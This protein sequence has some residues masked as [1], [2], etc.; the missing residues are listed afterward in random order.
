MFVRVCYKNA[1]QC[2]RIRGM[3]CG[4]YGLRDVIGQGHVIKQD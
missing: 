4:V 2:I 3:C 1:A